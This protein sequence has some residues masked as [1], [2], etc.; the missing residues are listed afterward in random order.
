MTWA[1]PVRAIELS[2]PKVRPPVPVQA[3]QFKEEQVSIKEA[4]RNVVDTTSLSDPDE[5]AAKVLS[6]LAPEDMAGAVADM[7]PQF[8][9]YTFSQGRMLNA[10]R[11]E[12]ASAPTRSSKVAAIR[13]AWSQR[14]DTIVNV[15]GIYK[16][17]GE[18][19][20]EDVLTIAAG[21]R[22]LAAQQEA[23]AHYYESIASALADGQTVAALKADPT[24]VAA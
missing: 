13:S 8:V 2:M 16:R 17:F 24:E 7:L 14:L 5:V 6:T 3:K 20:R 19:N 23:K 22:E 4:I 12:S 15:G 1:G 9:R 11:P 10:P 21:L 18:C